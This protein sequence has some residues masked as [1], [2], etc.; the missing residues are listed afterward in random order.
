MLSFKENHTLI[1]KGLAFQTQCSEFAE[2]KYLLK[3]FSV[4]VVLYTVMLCKR[5]LQVSDWKNMKERCERGV[6]QQVMIEGAFLCKSENPAT[7]ILDS[8]FRSSITCFA[9]QSQR[10][11]NSGDEDRQ[12][13]NIIT[14]FSFLR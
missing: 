11:T 12:V 2:S 9:P 3:H 6:G 10:P 8:K 1:I 7:R 13:E 5:A 4:G 14:L